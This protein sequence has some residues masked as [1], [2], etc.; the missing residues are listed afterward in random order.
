MKQEVDPARLDM[1]KVHGFHADIREL[2]HPA[3]TRARDGGMLQRLR[4]L[5]RLLR[6][7]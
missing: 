5:G 1:T 4:G 3:A 7:R 2:L 6:G